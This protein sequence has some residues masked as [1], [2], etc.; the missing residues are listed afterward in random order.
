MDNSAEPTGD[1]AATQLMDNLFSP[2]QS[3]QPGP[4]PGPAPATPQL[5][6]EPEPLDPMNIDWATGS[7]PPASPEPPKPENTP[8]PESAK[9]QGGGD[10]A[11]PSPLDLRTVLERHIE[12]PE[13]LFSDDKKI[14]QFREL[15]GLFEG[16][17][18]EL[19][20]AQLELQDLRSK[21]S[22]EPGGPDAQLLPESDAVQQLQSRIAEL[23]P[24]AKQWQ[25]QEAKQ[26]LQSNPAFRGEF[27]QPRASILREL[28][29]TADEIYLERS[30]VEEFLKLDSEY[31]QARWINENIADPTAH[32]LYKEK[33]ARFL[34][35]TQAREQAVN[36]DDP[37]A[38]LREW[39]DY[40]SAFATQFAAKLD[41][42]Q[43]KQLQAATERVVSGL[44][45]ENADPFFQT[46]AG[47]QVVADLVNRVGQGHGFAPEEVVEAMAHRSRADAYQALAANLKQRLDEMQ[48]QLGRFRGA[49]PPARP[50]AQPTKSTP[51]GSADWMSE[52]DVKEAGQSGGVTKP[53]IS[54]EQVQQASSVSR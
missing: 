38:A 13:K 3:P 33:G 8:L 51:T 12:D 22:V 48:S 28:E 6:G 39:E 45:G 29:A 54:L 52:F 11:E 21:A 24:A 34:E 43:A 7:T 18:K 4:T 25:E 42:S 53:L 49:N 50:A 2:P 35:L 20:A 1:S 15:R 31:K 41:E 5:K 9:P 30:E 16:V 36:V 40:E 37:L 19:E 17:T 44:T 32:Q 46:D 14:T 26:Q 10:N 47:K 23:E 27:D